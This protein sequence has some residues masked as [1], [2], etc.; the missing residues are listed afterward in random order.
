M[1]QNITPCSASSFLKVVAID[2]LSNT[3]STATFVSFFCSVRGIP[4]LSKVSK[5]LGSTSSKLEIFSFCL[6]A[7]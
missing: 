2:T 6:G 1:E 5:S 3:A 7:E 4:N